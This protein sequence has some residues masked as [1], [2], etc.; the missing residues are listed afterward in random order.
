MIQ[1]SAETG[2]CADKDMKKIYFCI[3]FYKKSSNP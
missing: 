2:Q 3:Q 1:L